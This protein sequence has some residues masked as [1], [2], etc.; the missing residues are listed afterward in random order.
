MPT[1]RV[2]EEPR[3]Y[4]E[5]LLALM[6]TLFFSLFNLVYFISAAIPGRIFLSLLFFL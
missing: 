1:S 6:P 4:R 5:E 3:V 2:V